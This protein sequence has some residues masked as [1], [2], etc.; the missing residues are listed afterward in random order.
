MRLHRCFQAALV[1]AAASITTASAR[2]DFFSAATSDEG[3]R[4]I[5]GASP[6][7]LVHGQLAQLTVSV[8][9]N[10]Q[11][12]VD[13][14]MEFSI[15]PISTLPN[16]AVITSATLFFDVSGAQSGGSPAALSVN[17]YPD[18]D[19]IVGLGDF[20]KPTTPLG[21]TGNLPQGAPGSLEIPFQIDATA[22]IQSLVN[23]RTRFVGF[24]FEGPGGDSSESIWGSDPANAAALRP[25]LDIT[26]T[27]AVPEPSSVLLMAIG[28][29]G[30]SGAAWRRGRSSPTGEDDARHRPSPQPR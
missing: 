18:G 20:L 26:F 8:A 27:A 5:I 13:S 30:I 15:A 17:G 29:A 23:A 2:A 7:T 3:T 6:A 14:I 19:G 1:A 11:A 21:G 9:G 16:G 24:H 25:H 4:Q 10:T 22:L 12:S 28:M